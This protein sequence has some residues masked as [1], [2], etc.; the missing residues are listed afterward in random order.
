[1]LNKRSK[2]EKVRSLNV[3]VDTWKSIIIFFIN[4]TNRF[5]KMIYFFLWFSSWNP[6]QHFQLYVNKKVLVTNQCTFSTQILQISQKGVSTAG[7]FS[8]V[9][10]NSSFFHKNNSRKKK[11]FTS[12]DKLL[13]PYHGSVELLL[14]VDVITH[15]T[16]CH[17][18]LTLVTRKKYSMR[19]TL[20]V[21]IVQWL[22]Q[23]CAFLV[24]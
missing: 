24:I 17:S 3:D 11:V 19:I 16:Q 20:S 1:M 22:F 14:L 23:N 7:T 10:S 9:K 8:S 12:Q 15:L 5:K 2:E 18:W 21:Y 6:N 13:S 4:K